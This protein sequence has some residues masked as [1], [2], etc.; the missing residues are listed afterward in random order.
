M[1]QLF[2]CQRPLPKT[3]VFHWNEFLSPNVLD[4]DGCFSREKPYHDQGD[5]LVWMGPQWTG[6]LA[7]ACIGGRYFG[8]IGFHSFTPK[9]VRRPSSFEG[10][11]G[12][13]GS[14]S[15]SSLSSEV[16]PRTL[17][18]SFSEP[19]LESERRPILRQEKKSTKINFW[20]RRPPAGVGVFTAGVGVFHVKGWG[21]K[22][23]CPPRPSLSSLGFEGR[24]LGCPGNFAGMSRPPW[25]V[26][27]VCAKNVCVHFSA[28][29]YVYIFET[30]YESNFVCL[31]KVLP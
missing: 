7:A 23:S 3:C 12:C 27:K 14:F 31:T 21:S 2:G 9:L 29:R 20:V 26:Q 8:T 19:F 5:S 13:S 10:R 25:G 16:L 17:P 11:N 18:R 15:V 6:L 4:L 28:P 24:N 22:S 1:K 30:C